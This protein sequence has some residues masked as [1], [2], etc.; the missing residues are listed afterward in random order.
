MEIATA[1]ALNCDLGD[2]TEG[3]IVAIEVPVLIDDPSEPYFGEIPAYQ[4]FDRIGV[5]VRAEIKPED[6]EAWLKLL[7]DS[8]ESLVLLN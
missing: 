3:F 8:D 5:P 6:I 1:G 7:Q 4:L 2:A